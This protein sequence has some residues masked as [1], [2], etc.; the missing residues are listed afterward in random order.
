M[1]TNKNIFNLDNGLVSSVF[2][3]FNKDSIVNRKIK[4]SGV[5]GITYSTFSTEFVIHVPSEYDY[6]LSSENRDLIIQY[7]FKGLEACGINELS[8]LF[9]VAHPFLFFN[10][11]CVIRKML[12]STILPLSRRERTT[13]STFTAPMFRNTPMP[14]LRTFCPISK[15][16]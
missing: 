10:S 5:V 3:I 12:T 1:F 7:I 8:F 2:T 9:V 14:C 6:R 16:N 15:R 11:H 13:K 4:L